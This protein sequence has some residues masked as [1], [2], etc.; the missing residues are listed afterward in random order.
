M[1][2]VAL[3]V[4]IAQ[5]AKRAR[6][7]WRRRRRR[8]ARRRRRRRPRGERRPRRSWRRLRRRDRGRAAGG[9]RA[10][11]AAACSDAGRARLVRRSSRRTAPSRT[12]LLD[13][14]NQHPERGRSEKGERLV[15]RRA[16]EFKLVEGRVRA[17]RTSS[18]TR[19]ASSAETR[20]PQPDDAPPRRGGRDRHAVKPG[21]QERGRE[22]G[23]R[24]HGRCRRGG[25]A[26]KAS[27]PDRRLGLGRGLKT[28]TRRD[29]MRRCC[30]WRFCDAG[31]HISH[32]TCRVCHLYL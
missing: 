9:E 8:R 27:S 32:D 15:L 14:R 7:G 23:L 31:I 24:G 28:T 13:V 16:R 20:V 25:E 19:R 11:L 1:R 2:E 12:S 30:A 6:R 22:Q 5:A 29:T 21:G 10:H 4:E 17:S 26:L 18:F 3:S